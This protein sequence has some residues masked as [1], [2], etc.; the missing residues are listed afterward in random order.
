MFVKQLVLSGFLLLLAAAPLCAMDAEVTTEDNSSDM[1]LGAT[2]LEGS[3][4]MVESAETEDLAMAPVDENVS[5]Y[6]DSMTTES[7]QIVPMKKGKAPVAEDMSTGIDGSFAQDSDI[8][9]VQ[10]SAS[11]MPTVEMPTAE[12][13]TADE[14][15]SSLE[16]KSDN[17]GQADVQGVFESM[18]REEEDESFP[19]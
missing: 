18:S 10:E 1:Q 19:G 7:D 11:E 5:M 17:Q 12:M 2:G 9:A 16:E 13:P 15:Q 4:S 6:R 8:N 3:D 14:Y